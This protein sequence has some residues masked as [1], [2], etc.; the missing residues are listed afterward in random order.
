MA[1]FRKRGDTWQYRITVR[2]PFTNKQKEYS[3]GGFR[4]KKEAQIA[5]I[6]REK[7]SLNGYE[8][9][10]IGLANYLRTW[11]EEY[12]DGKLRKNTIRTYRY[13]VESHAIPYFGNID[14]KDLKPLMYQKFINDKLEAGLSTETAKRIHN[15]INQA[16][17]R[18]VINNYIEKNPC[19]GVKI[20]RREVKQL[21]YLE[22]KFVTPFLQ[23]AYRRSNI[24]GL[25]FECLFESGLRK[26][27]AASIQWSKINWKEETISIDQ[28]LDFQPDEDDELFG[29]TKSYSSERVIKIRKSYMMKLQAHLK[30]QN[31]RKLN[32][33]DL[34]QHELNLVFCRDDGSPLP[35]STLYN[36]FRTCLEKI[37]A[38]RLPIHSTRH[39]HAV[40]LLEAGAD[41]KM[42]QERLGHHSM[43]VTSDIYAHMSKRIETRSIEKFDSYMKEIE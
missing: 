31:E 32:L 7:S 21:K 34:Y 26:G 12:V 5:A 18:A 22:P 38:P 1:S 33:G 4:T 14:L 15:T 41:M 11:L 43:Q 10:E 8:Q 37:G 20:V 30:Y 39:T 9:G 3:K 27:E 36:I 35:K 23:E 24:Y 17:K 25:F 19:E 16:Y 6:D 29:D 2:D 13:V 28:T 40:M 42:V